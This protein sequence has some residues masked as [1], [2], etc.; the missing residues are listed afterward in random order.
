MN[1]CLKMQVKLLIYTNS[2]HIFRGSLSDIQID[3]DRERANS[4]ALDKQIKEKNKMMFVL[5]YY[6]KY[7]FHNYNYL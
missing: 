5:F 1:K 3:L 4:K 2:V 7:L 6:I